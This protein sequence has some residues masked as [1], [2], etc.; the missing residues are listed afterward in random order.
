MVWISIYYITGIIGGSIWSKYPYTTFF[1]YLLI[2]LVPIIISILYGDK[3]T[4]LFLI[5]SF[6]VAYVLYFIHPVTLESHVMNQE[7]VMIG[8]VVDQKSSD[9]HL[10]LVVDDVKIIEQQKVKRL[11]SKVQVVTDNQK[12]YKIGSQIRVRG[13][14]QPMNKQMNPSDMNYSLYLKS[15]G[16]SSKIEAKDIDRVGQRWSMLPTLQKHIYN[17]IQ[18]VFKNEDQ[19]MISKLLI[20][21]D[22]GLEPSVEELYYGLGIGHV[23]SISGLHIGILY[24]IGWW[25]LGKIKI[26]YKYRMIG[27]LVFIWGYAFLIGFNI[28]AVRA[29]ILLTVIYVARILWKEEDIPIG[30]SI[31]ALVLLINNPYQLFQVGFQLS[32]IA[33]G[34][35]FLIGEG[36]RYCKLHGYRT[37]YYLLVGGGNILLSIVI[38]PILA[39]HFYEIPVVGVLLNYIAIPV[40]TL[41]IPISLLTIVVSYMTLQ[42]ASLVAVGISMLLRNIT[43][44][45]SFIEQ[46]P[47]STLV[48]GKPSFLEVGIFYFTVAIGI[49]CFIGWGYGKY[50][51]Y[52]TLFLLGIQVFST[53]QKREYLDITHLYVGQGDSTV[54]ITPT[55]HVV[56]IDG[57]GKGK[58]KTVERYIKYRGYDVI[59]YAVVSHGH[60]DHMGGVLGLMDED[61]T[62]KNVM[63]PSM[64][65]DNE[66]EI[67]LKGRCVT[68]RIP[69]KTLEGSETIQLGAVRLQFR[70]SQGMWDD[71]NDRS[72][73]SILSYGSYS[74]LFTGDMTKNVEEE[75]GHTLPPV[76]VL[77]VAHHGSET[78]T[79]EKF[80][81]HITP[82]YGM[83]S[84][85][86]DN[87]Y[88]HP[89]RSVIDRLERRGIIPL[90]TDQRGAIRIVTNGKKLSM[91]SHIQED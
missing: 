2:C 5:V 7:V 34:S 63:M 45:A 90:R 28:S 21:S 74:Q 51:A 19:G 75:I 44:I 39:W 77:K 41:L 70:V 52:A 91:A 24:G 16:V 64:G 53:L 56:L 69:Y 47:F 29:C 43:H 15:R 73:L 60:D 11:R 23:L 58:E 20:N 12:D 26:K 71:V 42:G 87:R 22:E 88:Q 35:I 78:S 49:S 9:Y 13:T 54:I 3:K 27:S 31:A 30:M 59:D 84:C 55:N 48:T 18:K 65:G 86:I 32:F 81:E 17:Q 62:I 83:I 38:T 57:G 76:T 66:G 10:I 68:K 46:L 80:L 36:L 37:R 14:M 72:A 79:T 61:I 40:F 1:M 67:A 6:I 4:W 25:I 85:G 33:Y 50:I 82:K 8:E 89:H